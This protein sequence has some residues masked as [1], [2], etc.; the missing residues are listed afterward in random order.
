MQKAVQAANQQMLSPAS[1]FPSLPVSQARVPPPH[2]LA[3]NSS[4]A[5]PLHCLPERRGKKK[6][7]SA[8]VGGKRV[9]RERSLK[10]ADSQGAIHLSGAAATPTVPSVQSALGKPSEAKRVPDNHSQSSRDFSQPPP[11][12]K[13]RVEERSVKPKKLSRDGG[14][15]GNGSGKEK[16]QQHTKQQSYGSSSGLW[17]FSPVKTNPPPVAATGGS[18]PPISAHKVF[19]QSD[20]FLHKA[21]SSSKAK[22]TSKDKQQEKEREKGKGGGEE[23]KKHKLLLT[24]GSGSNANND[25]GRFNDISAVKKENGEV[26]LPPKGKLL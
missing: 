24:S 16:L 13:V 25:V 19:K 10:M 5:P 23:K 22:K 1:I 15:G 11:P 6:A 8:A 18:Q 4:S 7:A 9:N 26:I 17:S 21:P 14:V 20:F 12:K 2:C 3:V